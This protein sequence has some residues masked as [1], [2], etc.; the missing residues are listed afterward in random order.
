[1]CLVRALTLEPKYLLLDEITSAQDV[2]HVKAM[3]GVIKKASSDGMSIILAT[4]LIRFARQLATRFYFM[5][6]GKIVESGST[7]I[8]RNPE[9]TRLKDFLLVSDEI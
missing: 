7:D 4:H 9:S 3:M 8:L 6:H 2:E 5:D 1:M